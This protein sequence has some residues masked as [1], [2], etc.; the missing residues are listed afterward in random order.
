MTSSKIQKD[1]VSACAQEIVKAIIDDLD[2]DFFEILVDESKDISHHEQMTIALRYVNK[3]GKVNERVIAIV[4]VG[5]TSTKTLKETICSLLMRH[6]L[7][8]SKI[9]GQGY[10][11]AS[12]MQGEMNGLKALILQETPSAYSTAKKYLLVDDFFAIISNVLNVVGASFKRRDQ[13]RDHHAEILEQLLES[14]HVLDAIKCG[15]SNFNDRLQAGAFLSMINEFE[16]AFLL[17]LMLKIL[18]M[19]NELS[20]SLQRKEQDIVNAM[21][22]LDITKKRLQLPSSVTYSHHLRVEL[23]YA[24]I[25]LQL[26]ELNNPFDVVSGNLLLGMASLNPINA[27]TNF[28][29]KKIMIFVKHFPDEFGESKLQELSYQLDTFIIHMRR[30]DPIFS[31]LKGIGDLAEALV[32]ANLVGTYSLMYLLVKLTLILPVATATVEKAFSSV[33]Y[34]KNKLRSSIGD[35]FLSNC[36]VCYIEKDIFINISNDVII[37]CFQNMKT[38]RYLV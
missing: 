15:G 16:F 18:V 22:F 37:D 8:T 32:N 2:G 38:R 19:S 10:D 30:G 7:S 23:F 12:S 21:I 34:I 9:R 20:A 14:V 5:D 3:K 35:A 36:L 27:F 13:L 6:S 26:Q 33:K 24:I 11:G 29:K 17:H 25:D 4:R 31:N 28:D 1:I